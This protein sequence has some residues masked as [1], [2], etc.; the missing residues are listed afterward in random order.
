MVLCGSPGASACEPIVREEGE[1]V[2]S[3][4]VRVAHVAAV[5]GIAAW[6]FIGWPAPGASA[7]LIRLAGCG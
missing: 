4:L 3:L 5:A 2:R 7:A 6:R 1:G